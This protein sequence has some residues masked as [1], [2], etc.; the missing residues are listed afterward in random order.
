MFYRSSII[1]A[2][3]QRTDK[4]NK[5]FFFSLQQDI[6][7]FQYKLRKHIYWIRIWQWDI[8]IIIFK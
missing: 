8:I 6:A 3:V 2:F 7:F 1:E 5:C 4:Y